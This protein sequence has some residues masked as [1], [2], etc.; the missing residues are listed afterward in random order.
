MR[1][2]FAI[3]AIFLAVAACAQEFKPYPKARITESQ[4]QSYFDEVRSKHGP[5]EKRFPSEHLVVFE[6]T[7]AMLTWAFTTAGHPAHP[8]WVTRQPVQDSRGV[9]LR[10]IGYFAGEEQPFAEMFRAYQALNERMREDFK[11]KSEKR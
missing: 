5:S 4:W 8:A 9:Y 10:Q 11:A 3:F 6:D 7:Q 1:L 2:L